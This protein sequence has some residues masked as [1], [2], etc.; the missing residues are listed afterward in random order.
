MYILTCN[1]CGKMY[2]AVN[3]QANIYTTDFGDELEN[4]FCGG[5]LSVME[6]WDF[7]AD[8]LF[9]VKGER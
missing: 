4:C 1:K 9:K 8:A 3:K 5:D 7:I 6:T 2:K